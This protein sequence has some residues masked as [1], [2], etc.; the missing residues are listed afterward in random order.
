M[1]GLKQNKTKQ[2]NPC[3]FNKKGG[4]PSK[5]PCPSRP[6]GI[7]RLT[8]ASLPC[9]P[10]PSYQKSPSNSC[11]PTAAGWAHT[12]TV[13]A[14]SEGLSRHGGGHKM[15]GG[16][17]WLPWE[18]WE[19]ALF[20]L[21]PF[22]RPSSANTVG[23][24]N[25]LVSVGSQTPSTMSGFTAVTLLV[26]RGPSL[27]WPSQP[28]LETPSSHMYL[29]GIKVHLT[30]FWRLDQ[31]DKAWYKIFH[32]NDIVRFE[33]AHRKKGQILLQCLQNLM[34]QRTFTRFGGGIK[35]D[36]STLYQ[37]IFQLQTL[38]TTTQKVAPGHFTFVWKSQFHDAKRVICKD[39]NLFAFC[40]KRSYLCTR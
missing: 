4:S 15:V 3:R 32:A 38:L 23:R 40:K 9:H 34:E 16:V 35:S 21:I 30:E 19:V 29:Q 12:H 36:A 27:I 33:F 37:R 20:S 25:D 39:I 10:W 31:A 2:K 24:T 11:L 8:F 18:P 7:L 5:K 13:H 26:Y 22:P 14:G 28:P 6:W 17:P 1:H